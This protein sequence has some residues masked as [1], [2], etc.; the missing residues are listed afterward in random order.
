[1]F[2]V[3][4]LDYYYAQKFIDSIDGHWLTVSAASKLYVVSRHKLTESI[5][6][7]L[8]PALRI[9]SHYYV[10]QAVIE[11]G[12]GLGFVPARRQVKSSVHKDQTSFLDMIDVTNEV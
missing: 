4:S 7:K 1:M 11:S 10:S 8:T 3:N 2:H 9:G 12:V 6:M 5:E